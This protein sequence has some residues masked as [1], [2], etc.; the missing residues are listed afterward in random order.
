MNTDNCHMLCLIT[1]GSASLFGIA[2]RLDP[3]ELPR[4]LP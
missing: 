2:L 3:I 4:S 1:F